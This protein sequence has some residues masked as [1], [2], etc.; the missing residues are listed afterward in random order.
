MATGIKKVNAA[1]GS[2]FANNINANLAGRR[3]PTFAP[4]K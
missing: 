3:L 1:D 4:V 2:V